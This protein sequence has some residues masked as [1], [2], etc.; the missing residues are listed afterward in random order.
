[1]AVPVAGSHSPT[2]VSSPAEA[3]SG[4]PSSDD[5]AVAR[6]LPLGR[7]RARDRHSQV[8]RRPGILGSHTSHITESPATTGIPHGIWNAPHICCR[9]GSRVGALPSG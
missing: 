9:S 4:R 7:P 8:L 5:L 3:S 2:V 1:M 6:H